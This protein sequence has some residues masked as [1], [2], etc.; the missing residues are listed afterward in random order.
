[1]WLGTPQSRKQGP[2]PESQ[3]QAAI[4]LKVGG[5]GRNPLDRDVVPRGADWAA[6]PL[7]VHFH[8]LSQVSPGAWV[9]QS[10][11]TDEAGT[12]RPLLVA[13]CQSQ[14]QDS[15]SS[16]TVPGREMPKTYTETYQ[17]SPDPVLGLRV[18][19]PASHRSA[20]GEED[21]KTFNDKCQRSPG[22]SSLSKWQGLAWCRKRTGWTIPHISCWASFPQNPP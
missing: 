12:F 13:L 14:T 6:G 18:K 10:H 16:C 7:S 22:P 17:P 20:T 15:S 4:S 19:G 8:K 3:V 1:M 2:R 9:P 21:F 5:E 11:A